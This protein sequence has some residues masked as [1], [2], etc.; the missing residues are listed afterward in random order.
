MLSSMMFEVF[1]DTQSRIRPEGDASRC[2]ESPTDGAQQTQRVLSGYREQPSALTG[3]LDLQIL[4]KGPGDKNGLQRAISF[5]LRAFACARPIAGNTC[6]VF[7][8][9][10]VN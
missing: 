10:P 1:L 4:F 3:G 6:T 5:H 2:L 7:Q 8:Y 9:S